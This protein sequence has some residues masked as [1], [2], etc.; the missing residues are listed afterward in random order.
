MLTLKGPCPV[1]N[2]T[3][4]SQTPK[5][6]TLLSPLSEVIV[7]TLFYIETLMSVSGVLSNDP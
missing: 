5:V 1:I 2:G 6:L 7:K 3:Y 4:L